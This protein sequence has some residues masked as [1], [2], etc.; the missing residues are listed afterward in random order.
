MMKNKEAKEAIKK[1]FEETPEMC[2]TAITRRIDISHKQAH[3]ICQELANECF[4]E[5]LGDPA[6]WV[7]NGDMCNVS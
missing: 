2:L 7:D 3:E 1:L 6:W 4:L 5:P